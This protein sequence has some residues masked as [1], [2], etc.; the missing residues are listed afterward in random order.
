M[1]EALKNIERVISEA[2]TRLN[3]PVKEGYLLVYGSDGDEVHVNL[4]TEEHYRKIIAAMEVSQQKA[5]EA[6]WET[7]PVQ[8]WFTQTYCVEPWPYNGVHVLGTVSVCC[9]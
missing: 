9:C 1:N 5:S 2:K 6:A 7:E 4:I 8:S 3:G